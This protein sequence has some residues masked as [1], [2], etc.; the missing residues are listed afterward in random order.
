LIAGFI[1]LG[2]QN[3]RFFAQTYPF[4]SVQLL[5]GGPH[6]NMKFYPTRHLR[7]AFIS[8]TAF[9]VLS[10]AVSA[11]PQFTRKVAVPNSILPVVAKSLPTITPLKGVGTQELL[12]VAISLKPK[13]AKGLEE[14]ANAVSN[15]KSDIYGQFMTPTEVGE[16]F[17]AE[18]KD[19]NAVVAFFI[20]NGMKVTHV[21]KTNI[22]VVATGTTAQVEAAFGTKIANLTV[23]ETD[24]NYSYRSNVTPIYVPVAFANKVQ[25]V[26]GVE[27]YSRPKHR[28]TTL[29][30]S[31]TRTLYS[32]NIPFNVG[33]TGA[34]RNVGISN[35]DGYRFSNAPLY[36]AAN[37]LPVPGGGVGSNLHAVTVDG[38]TIA[39]GAAGG[40]GDL[41]FQMVLGSS[42][43]ADITMYTGL[44]T[45]AGLI[46]LLSREVTDNTMDIISESWGWN[47]P[48]ATA[49]S[50]H[51]HHTTMTAV[52]I[53][54]CVA[55]GDSGT[56]FGVFDYPD[57][58]PDVLLVGGTV[59][60]TDVSGNRNSEVAWSLSG[61]WGGGGGWCTS[62]AANAA[63]FNVRPSWQVGTG[64]PSAG[65]VNK[66]LVPD[67]A[68]HASGA[69]GATTAAYVIYINGVA[70]GLLGTSASSPFFAGG[71][72]NVEHRLYSTGGR[73]ANTNKG[74]LGR[75]ADRIYAQNG[76]PDIWF[77]VTSGNIGNLPA[78]GGGALNGTPANAT[79]GWDFATGWGAINFNTFYKSFFEAR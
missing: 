43:L 33:Y 11:A 58:D 34:G 76:R 63:V 10:I 15:P 73:G 74:R 31:Q 6:K 5:G 67:V 62:T 1:L 13:D 17:G 25:S 12:T 54:Y 26:D 69:P 53:T 41:D 23:A 22:T 79:A 30:A 16:K 9:G 56:S 7:R 29:S 66:R 57:Y 36:V 61:G 47:I 42:P 71:L 49:A 75:I 78:S 3:L 68:L 24:G 20:T 32:L 70:N 4:P 72:A 52:G 46:S 8:L 59:A 65:V 21:G 37:S 48:S 18:Q 38:S 27:T 40:E 64:I 45:G 60:D 39:S 19:I 77:D 28:G 2:S 44:G 14:F 35:W 55:S 51:T 50:C